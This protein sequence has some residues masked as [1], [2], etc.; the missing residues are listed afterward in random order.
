VVSGRAPSRMPPPFPHT[1][2]ASLRR[3]T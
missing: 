2:S 3:S 1:S